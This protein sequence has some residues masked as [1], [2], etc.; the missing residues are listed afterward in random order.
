[1]GS[2]I[3]SISNCAA[4]VYKEVACA[5]FEFSSIDGIERITKV[6]IPVLE[7]AG[8]LQGNSQMYKSC[9]K[10]LKDLKCDYY[11]TKWIESLADFTKKKS[12]KLEFKIA[13]TQPFILAIANFCELGSFLQ[14][15][16]VLS[17]SWCSKRAA[18]FGSCRVWKT[19][20]TISEIP[21]IDTLCY[22]P[23]DFFIAISSAYDICVALQKIYGVLCCNEEDSLLEAGL[24]I[25]NSIGKI[26]LIG[27]GK[28][29]FYV[30]WFKILEI[31]TGGVSV[32]SK[33]VKDRNTRLKA[34]RNLI[35]QGKGG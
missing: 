7:L 19:S 31:S 25:T 4:S 13:D 6:A 10:S 8:E 14:S 18:Q 22:R 24:K 3:N 34:E 28:Y 17:F 5:L 16:N 9:L 20:L 30:P 21:Y 35:E 11:A 32:L 15:H 2:Y 12:G 1:M 26:L 27:L 23:K 33:V 29:Y